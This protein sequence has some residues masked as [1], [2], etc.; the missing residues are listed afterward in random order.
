MIFGVV[1]Q[2]RIQDFP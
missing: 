1:K 2:E